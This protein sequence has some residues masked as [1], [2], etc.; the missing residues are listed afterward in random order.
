MCRSRRSRKGRSGCSAPPRIQPLSRPHPH[1][2]HRLGH[3]QA[4][5]ERSRFSRATARSSKPAASPRCWPSAG[6]SAYPDRG[7]DSGDIVSPSPADQGLGR[8]HLLRSV[9]RYAAAGAADR[10]ADAVDD[11]PHQRFPAR[12]HRRRQG[13]EPRHPRPPVREAEGNVA[14]KIE[15]ADDKDSLD[16]RRRPRRIA[17]RHP[18]RDHAPRRLR[19]RRLASARRAEARRGGQL[20]EPIEEVVI[21]VDEE[22]SGVVV[23]KMSERK[24]DMLE[25]RP[26]GGGALRLVFHA[27]P[28]A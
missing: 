19:A 16:D 13:A 8:R 10:S 23:Q 24:A 3:G 11:L 2:P 4:E 12:R 17:A 20:L 21:D 9:G 14:L 15:E 1:R 22:H 18:D 26:S 27:R 5:P 7:G 28:A 25:M 6:S